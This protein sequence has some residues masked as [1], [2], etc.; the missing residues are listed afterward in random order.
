LFKQF[1]TGVA[2]TGTTTYPIDPPLY[3]RYARLINN[4]GGNGTEYTFETTGE[5]TFTIA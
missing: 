5:L 3:A 2:G 1:G 4:D